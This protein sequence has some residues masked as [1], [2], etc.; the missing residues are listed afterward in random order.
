MERLSGEQII[1]RIFITE[2]DK[3]EG[4]L[5]YH[6]IVDMLRDEG[7]AGATVLRGICGYGGKGHVH[8]TSILSLS[9]D[10]PVVIEAVDSQ[11]NIEK[12][13]PKIDGMI[14]TGLVTTEPVNVLRHFNQ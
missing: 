13:L 7:I 2:T 8:K 6:L 14:K 9:Q 3:F 4:K 5:L 10:L 1:L 11:E 12:I